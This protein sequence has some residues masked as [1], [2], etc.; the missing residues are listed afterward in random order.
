M[1]RRLEKTIA[2]IK[3]PSKKQ[4]TSLYVSKNNEVFLFDKTLERISKD[5]QKETLATF[6]TPINLITLQNDRIFISL[7]NSGIAEYNTSTKSLTDHRKNRL[8][9]RSLPAGA[10][11]FL[12]DKNTLWIGS[13]ESGLYEIDISDKNLFKAKQHH[14][15]YGIIK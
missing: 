5:G 11:T 6:D 9:S 4:K 2:Q 10:S 14:T 3:T 7:K 13:D 15:R 8:L 12:L 1:L